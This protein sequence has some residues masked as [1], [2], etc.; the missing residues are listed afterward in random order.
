[1]KAR[2]SQ[3]TRSRGVEFSDFSNFVA[4]HLG[5]AVVV[6][7]IALFSALMA[8]RGERRDHK[9]ARKEASDV[10]AE[11]DASAKREAEMS[12]EVRAAKVK[13]ELNKELKELG[14]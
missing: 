10:V 13:A 2:I 3:V 7:A 11:M 9:S 6:L 12:G 1:M 5:F 4:T 8:F 14:L